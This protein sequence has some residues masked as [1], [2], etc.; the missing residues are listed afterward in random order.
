[1]TKGTTMKIKHLASSII[2]ISGLGLTQANAGFEDALKGALNSFGGSDILQQ[3]AISSLSNSDMIDGLKEALA[4]GVESAINTLGKKD[5]F[6]SNQ[7][8]KIPMPDS[9]QSMESIAL[10][11]GQGQYIDRFVASM[12]HAAEDAVPDASKILGDAIRD[13]SV[14][15]AANIVNGPDD[16]ATQYFKQFSSEKLKSTFL[17]VVQQA[18]DKAG[19]TSAY[20]GVVN[21]GSGMLNQFTSGMGIPSMGDSVKDSLDLDQYITDQTLEGLFTYI[22]IE[23]KRIRDNPTAR[24]TDLLKKVFGQ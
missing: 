14:E 9:V 17:P 4:N 3:K 19:V 21:Q 24:T 8:V 16:A 22:A 11:M 1:M 6:L 5:G 10:K 23:E 2:L 20:K 12:N 13:M 18:T 7:L 15:D